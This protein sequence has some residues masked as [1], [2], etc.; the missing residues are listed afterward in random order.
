MRD[1]L[2]HLSRVDLKLAVVISKSRVCELKPE[3]GFKP[4]I[5]LCSAIAHQQLTGKAAQTILGRY[6]A[7]L[8][9]GDWPTAEKI[10][11]VKLDKLRACGFSNAKAAALKD[12][13]VKT[14]DGTIPTVKALAKLSDEEIIERLTQVRGVGQWTVEMLLMFRL[15]RLDVMPAGDYGVRKGFTRLYRKKELV[16]PKALLKHAEKWKPYRSVAAWYCWRVL[17]AP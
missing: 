2:D 8:G 5:A 1:A 6:K 16:T 10:S 9:G 15:G 13:A 3:K 12:C 14:L 4:F 7:Q 17:D 11:R